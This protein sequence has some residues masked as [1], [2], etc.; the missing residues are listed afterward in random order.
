M[1]EHL[2]LIVTI[3]AGLAV[4]LALGFAMH[5]LGLSPVVGYVCAGIVVGPSTPGFVANE[6]LAGELAE[7]G[8]ILLM[9]GVGLQ[10]HLRE[11]IAVRRVAILGAFGQIVGSTLLGAWLAHR[12]GYRISDGLVLGFALSIASTVV[13]VRVLSEQRQTH[14][15]VGKLAL[16]WLVVEDIVTV[17]AL[18]ALPAAGKGGSSTHQLLLAL[19]WAALKLAFLVGV[20][21]VIGQRV[22]PRL[23]SYVAQ[24]RSRELFTL[25]VLVT[26]LGIAV[27]SSVLFGASM[28]LGAF[29]AGMVVGQSEFSARAASDALPMRDAFAVLFFVS[30]GMLL[31]PGRLLD[32]VGLAALVIA[33]IVVGKPLAAIGVARA[34]GT[35]LAMALPVGASLAQIGEFSFIVIGLGRQL[36]VLPA[37]AS[38]KAVVASIVSITL[39]PLVYRAAEAAARRL[40][41]RR[42]AR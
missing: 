23:F 40:A 26:A 20:M 30:E 14:A 13:M 18:V 42:P 28:A 31:D 7:V 22:I 32:G 11:L 25:T 34:L 19:G 5:R 17:L 8:V 16:G 12:W 29:L 33:V 2:E 6:R 3:T 10:F 15:R 41:V 37:A 35:P 1:A 21:L 24:T 38:Q 39:C 4:A 36:G 9:F 27:C